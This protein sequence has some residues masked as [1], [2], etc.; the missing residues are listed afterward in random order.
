MSKMFYLD[1]KTFLVDD[2]LT[3]VDRASMANSLEVR[4]P[5]LDHKLVEFAYTLPL[6]YKLRG[7]TTK[8]LLRKTMQR[9]FPASHLNLD[10]RGFG[11]PLR[12]WMR[13]A[14]RDWVH[15]TIFETPETANFLNRPGVEQIWQRFQNGESQFSRVLA[16]LLSLAISSRVWA[17]SSPGFARETIVGPLAAQGFS[18]TSVMGMVK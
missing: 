6:R 17:H 14:L 11:I 9:H 13:G 18:S 15:A 5:L 12:P 8:Y 7:R 4:V 10:K 16:V 3:K 1:I 2:I